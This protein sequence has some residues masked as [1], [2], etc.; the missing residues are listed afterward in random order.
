V[1]RRRFTELFRAQWLAL[2]RDRA[3]MFFIFLFPLMFLLI[4][5]LLIPDGES[6]R[7]TLLVTGSGPVI[8]NLPTQVLDIVRVDDPAEALEKVRNGDEP[9]LLEQR[10]EVLTLRFAASDQVQ[11]GTIRGIVSSVV[12]TA[13][14][15]AA[16]VSTPR[17]TLRAEQ[18][19]DDSLD[20]IEF[21]T[22]G[23][24]GWAVSI[25]AV[26]GAALTLVTWRD[27]RVLLRLRLAPV[28][29]AEI[30][31]S[32]VLLS[33][34]LAIGQVVLYVGAGVVFF[35]LSPTSGWWMCFPIA[36]AGT[37]AFLSVG[38]VVGA[39]SKTVDSASAIANLITLPM[40]FL[41]GAFFPLDD[42]PGWVQGVAN[43]L[44]MKHIITGMTDT[45][46]RGL[47]PASALPEIGILLLFT[48]V[49]GA[50]AVHP[51][52]FRWSAV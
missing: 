7:S 17:F 10:G 49:V 43:L 40:A 16:G 22:P 2:V 33:T 21:F 31:G 50:I 6:S 32:R 15:R 52:V 9:A 11:A 38:L 30:A 18:V 13:N 44:P 29:L 8:D 28:R 34:I 25:A 47:G 27:K 20:P 45:M 35:D 12:D 37:L 48:V 5:G 39:V 41:S 19:E 24:L 14:L 42:A 4:F 51:R 46:V 23:I 26:F 36:I 1:N 3:A